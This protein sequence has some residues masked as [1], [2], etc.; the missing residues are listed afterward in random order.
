MGRA[1]H[2]AILA[3]A[4]AGCGGPPPVE[5]EFLVFGTTAELTLRGEGASAPAADDVERLFAAR[6][7]EWHPWRDSALTRLNAALAAGAPHQTLPSIVDLI[8]TSRPLVADSGGR[9][10]PAAG[11][12]V[13]AWGFHTSEWPART[14]VDAAWVERWPRMRPHFASLRLAGLRIESADGGLRLDFNAVA[15]GVAARDALALLRTRGV[16]HALL[17]LGGDVAALGDAGGRP[18]RV[19][20]RDPR[21]GVLGWVALHDGEGLFA[22]GSYAKFRDDPD[23][24]RPHVVDPRSGQP[25]SGS[26]AS[27]VLSA[28]LP[29]ADAGATALMVAG[30]DEAAA[31]AASMRLGCVLLLTDDDELLLSEGLRARLH[32]LREPAR[33]TLLPG[34]PAC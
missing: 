17:D 20:L 14:P 34:G 10:D 11:A 18:W 4:L 2:A 1:A 21:G 19:A 7:A 8:E 5:R 27:A 3:L 12:L 16:R 26:A 13:A 15:E 31:L 25:V 23:R 30:R 32:L 6:D 28:D 29:R 24:R 22:S 33:R 9:F